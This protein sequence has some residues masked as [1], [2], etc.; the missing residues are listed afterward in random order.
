MVALFTAPVE[1]SVAPLFGPEAGGTL[2]TIMYSFWQDGV[3]TADHFAERVTVTLG[4]MP[5]SHNMTYASF[6]FKY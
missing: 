6:A 1:F 5:L 3:T 2:L 4:G